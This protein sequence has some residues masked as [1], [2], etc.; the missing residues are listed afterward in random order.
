MT[1]F[2]VCHG[3]HSF[4]I[5]WKKIKAHVGSYVYWDHF[6]VFFLPVFVFK[7]VEFEAFGP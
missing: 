7:C 3:S 6:A 4:Q 2:H 1:T 5:L